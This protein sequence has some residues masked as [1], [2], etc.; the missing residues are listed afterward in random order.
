[1]KAEDDHDTTAYTINVV[2]ESERQWTADERA[3]A[4]LNKTFEISVTINGPDSVKDAIIDALRDYLNAPYAEF[5]FDLSNYNIEGTGTT[6]QISN[7]AVTCIANE[8]S[9]DTVINVILN[10]TNA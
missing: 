4:L 5:E 7:L 1:M 2:V 9:A 3:E 8:A 10:Y 6:N